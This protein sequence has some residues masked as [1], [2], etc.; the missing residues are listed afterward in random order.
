MDAILKKELRRIPVLGIFEGGLWKTKGFQAPIYVGDPI[1]AL[2]VFNEKEADEI[3]LMGFRQTLHGRGLPRQ[4]LSNLAGEAQMPLG[5]GGGI[6]H[7]DEVKWL[8]DTGFEKVVFNTAL[9]TQPALIEGSAA[10]MG[11]SSV[12]VSLDYRRNANGVRTCFTHS[13]TVPLGME[14]SEAAVFA[15]GLGAGELLVHHIEGDGLYPGYDSSALDLLATTTDLPLV[16]AGGCRG[17]LDFSDESLATAS[18]LAAS[19]C[20]VFY[21]RHKAVLIHYP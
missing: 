4:M 16:L 12:V 8:M 9:G 7:L 20:F 21:G 3:L 11:S 19:S 6:A 2:R 5:Y 15:G 10:L 14:L 13:G 17:K 1:N 18:G